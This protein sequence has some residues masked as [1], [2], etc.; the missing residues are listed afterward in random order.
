MAEEETPFSKQ[1]RLAT[2]EI[3]ANS[4]ALVNAKLA[5]GKN[6]FV[7]AAYLIFLKTFKI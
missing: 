7:M 5:F 2:R 6:T 3:H 1:M 4:D